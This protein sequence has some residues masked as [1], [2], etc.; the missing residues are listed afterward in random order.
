MRQVID[1]WN[2]SALIR[3]MIGD[4]A[5][6]TTYANPRYVDPVGGSDSNDGLTTA[7]A[8]K[9]VTKVNNTTIPAG[10]AILFKRGATYTTSLV[11]D[12]SGTSSNRIVV[13]S[14]GTGALPIFDGGAAR[15]P[16]QVTGNWVT[17]QDIQVQNA[18]QSDKVGLGVYGTDCLVQRVTATG[19]AIGIQAYNGAHRMRVTASSPSN[20]TVVINPD[21][22]APGSGSTDDYGA[23]GIGILQADNCEVD[24]N[25][26]VG[27]VG[28][29]ADFG[30]DGSAVEIYGSIGTVVHHNTCTGNQTFCELGDVRSDGNVFH[31]NLIV[32]DLA[33][34]IGVNAQG[35]GTFG[36]VT[37][38]KFHHNT[39]VLTATGTMGLLADSGATFAAH[40]NIVQAEYLGWTADKIDEGHNVYVGSGGNDIQSTANAG[41]GIAS[42]STTTTTPGFVSSSDYHL[43]AGS[44]AINR[45]SPWPTWEAP[46][47]TTC[48]APWGPHP[49]PAATSGSPDHPR[50]KEFPRW[51]C[52]QVLP[53]R[54]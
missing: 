36:P 22:S 34:S 18:G 11:V 14:Y 51:P 29:S 10:A 12:N 48:P 9:T 30:E 25:T 50:R 27:N 2:G 40:N 24:H 33:N 41:T 5:P 4:A 47:S 17:V 37:N 46:T 6:A 53:Q 7:T 39:V 54:R 19:N 43:A 42:T 31:N 35:V 13:G 1:K 32:S 21:G 8:W 20:N 3:Q 38:T 28:P 52:L 26:I 16:V 15:Y 49:I 45:A 23:C 44:T